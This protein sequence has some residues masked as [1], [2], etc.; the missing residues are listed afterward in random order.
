MRC[1][2]AVLRDALGERTEAF[3]EIER[4]FD[5]NSAF[6][7]SIDVDPKM[8]TFRDDR[9]FTRLQRRSRQ[10]ELQQSQRT[11]SSN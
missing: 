6:L 11:R 9:R 7:Y 3:K 2:V 4:A 10:K 1:I 5:E 8:D